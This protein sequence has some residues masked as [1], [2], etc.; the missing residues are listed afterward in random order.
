MSDEYDFETTETFR[1]KMAQL[2][3]E[4]NSYVESLISAK[5]YLLEV[6]R[7]L[8][9]EVDLSTSMGEPVEKSLLDKYQAVIKYYDNE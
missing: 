8:H 3:G 7:D 1:K 6:L 9:R 4:S 5:K 2:R